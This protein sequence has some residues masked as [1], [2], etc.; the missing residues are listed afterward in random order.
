LLIKAIAINGEAK[1]ATHTS[2]IK[3]VWQEFHQRLRGFLL[4]RVKNPADADDI[5]QEVFIRIHQH[6]TTVR[7][8]DR[9]QSWI[10]QIT[11]NAIIDYYRK[12]NRQPEFTSEAALETLAMDEKPE[13]FNQQMAGC[14]RPLLEHLPAPY[15]EAV[16]LADLEGITQ[17]AIAQKLGISLS[18]MK[19]RVQRGRQKLKDLL[20]TCCQIE[21]DAMGNAIKYEMK[22]LSMCR[23]CGL[24]E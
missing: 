23:S 7:D 8:S 22:D 20:Q 4:Q 18:G 24:A 21:M 15:R 11:R 5:L 9:L 3:T 16:Q 6:L 19:S 17:S 10:F 14:L 1:M 12:V 2:D 13:V